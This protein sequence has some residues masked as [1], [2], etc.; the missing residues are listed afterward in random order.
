VQEGFGVSLALPSLIGAAGVE[1][2]LMPQMSRQEEAALRASAQ[3]IADASAR[4]KQ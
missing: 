3:H 1:R 4:L 2:V